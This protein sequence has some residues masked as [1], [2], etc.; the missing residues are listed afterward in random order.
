MRQT[1]ARQQRPASGTAPERR[2]GG[3]QRN[4]TGQGG[5][6]PGGA[7]AAA[8]AA[9]AQQGPIYAVLCL[10]TGRAGRY[11]QNRQRA[12]SRPIPARRGAQPV[13]LR[14]EMHEQRPALIRASHADAGA[15]AA[16]TCP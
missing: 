7:R 5:I 13:R 3:C 9:T 16:A 12:S 6:P 1:P 10:F 8:V 11:S 2:R 14:A 15:E 4:A